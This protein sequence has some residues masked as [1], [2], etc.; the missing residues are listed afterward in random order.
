MHGVEEE[1][2]WMTLVAHKISNQ[3]TASERLSWTAYNID[4]N[5]DNVD[6][7]NCLISTLPV[8]DHVADD[9][10]FQIHIM[11]KNLQIV[12]HLNPGQTAVAGCDQPLYAKKKVGLWAFPSKFAKKM[13]F[14]Y[15]ENG[16]EKREEIE[17]YTEDIFAFF[18]PLHIEKAILSCFGDLVKGTGLD[19][20]MKSAGLSTVGLVTAMCDVNH[21]KKARYTCQVVGPVLQSLLEDAFSATQEES[22]LDEWTDQK[23]E[24]STIFKYY[25]GLLEHL[26][27]INLFVRSLREANFELFI[28]SLEKVCPLFFALDHYNYARWVPVFVHDLKL[29]KTKDPE[30]FNLFQKGYFVVNKTST[31]FSKMGFDQSLEQCNKNIKSPS[32]ISCLL[33]KKDKEFLRKLEHVLPEIEDY[34]DNVE[35]CTNVKDAK[36]KEESP[37]FISKFL[38]DCSKVRNAISTNPF[39]HDQAVKLN[40]TDL[41][42]RVVL[43]GMEEVFRVGIIQFNE[44]NRTRFVLGKCD[45]ISTKIEM[46]KLKLPK[47]AEN[48]LTLESPVEIKLTPKNIVL[49]R[50]ACIFREKASQKLFATEFTG[51]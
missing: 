11:D 47:N 15:F 41:F 4:Q 16:I 29:L 12:R 13:L 26:R 39:T 19:D 44:Y 22:S 32:G 33:N 2:K 18:G 30:L 20:V 49:L 10:K 45:V 24:T 3:N 38:S 8:I 37:G 23:K 42:P 36:H 43:K 6:H 51:E 1:K 21:I 9:Y 40:S 5:R 35:S 50:E 17:T 25:C 48:L 46:N 34:L 28:S 27:H 31:K 14:T 7:Q